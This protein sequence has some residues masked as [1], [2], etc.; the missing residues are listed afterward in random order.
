MLFSIAAVV[1][2]KENL[3]AGGG[4]GNPMSA[5]LRQL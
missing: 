3:T 2:S 5:A 1:Y 4:S